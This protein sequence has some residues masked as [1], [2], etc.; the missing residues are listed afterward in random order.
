[1]TPTITGGTII[2]NVFSMRLAKIK[3][4]T[5]C[6]GHTTSL[7]GAILELSCYNVAPKLQSLRKRI[8]NPRIGNKQQELS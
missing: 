4:R 8:N 5:T 6:K 1:M 7:P 2:G 3:H